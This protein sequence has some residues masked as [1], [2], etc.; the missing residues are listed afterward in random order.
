MTF[1][2]CLKSFPCGISTFLVVCSF[3]APFLPIPPVAGRTSI[4]LPPRPLVLKPPFVFRAFRARGWLMTL[5]PG[6]GLSS[7]PKHLGY[8]TLIFGFLFFPRKAHRRFF[9][10]SGTSFVS[11][12]NPTCLYG[13]RC[14][15]FDT[16]FFP[17]SCFGSPPPPPSS[18]SLHQR[19]T[20]S[21][22]IRMLFFAAVS[23]TTGPIIGRLPR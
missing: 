22:L 21:S 6:S 17:P 2:R 10:F 16:F 23:F 1:S 11:H 13:Y 7:L 19:T 3:E 4:V 12:N 20:K 15:G 8:K 18:V 9:L 14:Y 5:F